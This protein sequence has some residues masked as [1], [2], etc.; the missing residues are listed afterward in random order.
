MPVARQP[1]YAEPVGANLKTYREIEAEEQLLVL[2][3]LVQ[4]FD[5]LVPIEPV[6]PDFGTQR[7]PSSASNSRQQSSELDADERRFVGV[8]GAIQ[9]DA[10]GQHRDTRPTEKK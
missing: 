8:A 3:A 4:G 9:T 2:R 7:S 10:R 5:C 6:G 1:G